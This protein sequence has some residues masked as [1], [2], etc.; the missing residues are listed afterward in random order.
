MAVAAVAAGLVVASGLRFYTVKTPSMG[1]VAPVGTLVVTRPA[2]DYRVGDIVTYERRNR[3]F[4]HRI[5]VANADGTFVTQGDLNGVPDPLAVTRDEIVG[6]AVLLAPGFGWLWQG[7]PWLILGGLAVYALSLLRRFDHTWR[8]VFRISGWTL[9]FCL[10]AVWLRPWVS[11]AQLAW[12]AS[13]IGGVDMHVV[14]TGLFPLDVLGQRLTS[15]QDAMVHVTQQNADGYYTLTPTLAFYWWEQVGLF[16]LCLIPLALS[17][18]IRTQPIQPARAIE[19]EPDDEVVEDPAGTSESDGTAGEP[20]PAASA[21]AAAAVA[22]EASLATELLGGPAGS[23]EAAPAEPLAEPA[24]A[25]PF[26]RRRLIL[27]AAIVLAL[28]VSVAVVTFTSTSAAVT[29]KINN[30]SNTAGTRTYFNCR[31]ALS[32]LGTGSTTVAFAMGT[33][34]SSEADI[35]GRTAKLNTGTYNTS[36]TTSATYGCNQDVPK[37]SVT[38]NGT[39][40]CLANK[41][42][43]SNPQTFSLEAWF[44]TSSAKAVKVIGFGVSQFNAS[45]STYDRHVYVDNLGR[46]VFGV[47]IGGYS[48]ISSPSGTDYSDGNWHHV[49]AT[50]KG[51]SGGTG[52]KLY[53]DG[54]LVA[55]NSGFTNA[56]NTTGYWKVGC[57]NLTG[58]P[59]AA[60]TSLVQTGTSANASGWFT[61]QIQ[62]AAV[63]TTEL[64]ATQVAAHYAAGAA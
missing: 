56:E 53:L 20:L 35:L 13:E 17:F 60:G 12:A 39:S 64:T 41:A 30:S 16:L 47:Y 37:A 31:N 44:R 7:L 59:N 58:W 34:G 36:A 18:L 29:A 42:T 4:T 8:W 32:S 23:P 24:K 3:S 51:G 19:D 62:Y 57:G 40:Q 28:I 1:T 10:V 38:F 33:T 22:V 2:D 55:S 9:V 11:L 25:D 63:F 49:V 52:A 14:N 21:T 50:Y 6:R 27:I 46:V 15:G 61:G 26:D 45:E 43:T 48:T 5:L 54:A